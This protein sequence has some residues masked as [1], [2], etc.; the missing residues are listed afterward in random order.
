L[1]IEIFVLERVLLEARG[2]C[3]LCEL[4]SFA[5]VEARIAHIVGRVG[6][7]TGGAILTARAVVEVEELVNTALGAGIGRPCAGETSR[8]ASIAR[9]VCLVI[10]FARCAS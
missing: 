5:V 3:G 8:R 6:D 1:L 10:E 4:A 2:A 9:V 7:P